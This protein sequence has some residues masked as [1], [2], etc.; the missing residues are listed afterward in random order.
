MGKFLPLLVQ[1]SDVC[2]QIFVLIGFVCKQASLD[3][4]ARDIR[5]RSVTKY[6]LHSRT[7]DLF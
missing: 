5:S 3:Y 4:V 2:S 7:S 1:E 6:S